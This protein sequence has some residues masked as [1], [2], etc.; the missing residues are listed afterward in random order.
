M[1]RLKDRVA[2]VLGAGSVGPGWGN[3][4]ASAVCYAREG[5]I[6][7]CVDVNLAA[8]EETAAIITGE[9][10]RAEIYQ[11][12]FNAD[13]ETYE[14]APTDES[15]FAQFTVGSTWTLKVNTFGTVMGVQP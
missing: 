15:Q 6:V 5:A 4:K 3:G 2:L 7:I 1:A 8:A 9:G 12:V 14:Y 11:V 13:G 10:G